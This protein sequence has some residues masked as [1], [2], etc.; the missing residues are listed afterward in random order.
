MVAAALGSCG[1]EH[2]NTVEPVQSQ[3][4]ESGLELVALEIASDGRTHRFIVEVART[5]DQQARGLMFRRSLGAD[6]GMIFPFEMPRPA[7][8]WMRNTL[9]PLDMIF[10]R[11]DGTIARVA[12]NTVPHSEESVT[13]G[14]PVASVLEIRGGRAAELGI[15]EGDR[16]SWPR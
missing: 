4:A 10:I 16:V 2:A 6:E 12:A 9:I 8:F 15:G 11:E 3:H 14:E 5:P 7:S 1:S 13:S